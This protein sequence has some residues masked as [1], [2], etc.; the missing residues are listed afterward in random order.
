MP[1]DYRDIPDNW[2]PAVAE[3]VADVEQEIRATDWENEP[4]SADISPV[5]QNGYQS[6]AQYQVPDSGMEKYYR[7]VVGE[8]R[9]RGHDAKL[10]DDG[11][12]E[13]RNPLW[14]GNYSAS[15]PQSRNASGLPMFV[16]LAI[17]LTSPFLWWLYCPVLFVY[18]TVKNPSM[19][20]LWLFLCFLPY[21]VIGG[22]YLAMVR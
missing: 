19:W 17:F 21:V 22:M 3:A 1:N 6:K 11:D 8:L 18:A 16:G 9:R 7:T 4:S 15:P 5:W 20:L 2:R 14:H 10:L 12:I 13:V